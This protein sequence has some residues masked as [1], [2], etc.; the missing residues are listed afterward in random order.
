MKIRKNQRGFALLLFA[1]VLMTAAAAVTIKALNNAGANSQIERDKITAAA[2]AQAKEALIGYAASDATRPGELPCP[3][4][5]G[6]GM[7][8]MGVDYNYGNR[9]CKS[10]IGYLPWKTLDLPELRD[11]AGKHLWYVISPNFYAGNYAALNSDSKGVLPV[12]SEN[13]TLIT[14]QSV[15]IIFSPG[16]ILPN[17]N[18]GNP[19]D[20][21]NYLEQISLNC[22]GSNCINGN[23]TIS[24][25]P[26]IAG[27]ILDTNKITL[28]NDKL[29]LIQTKDLIPVVEKRVAKELF[30]WLQSYYSAN[31]YYPYPA[32]Y[33]HCDNENCQGD[34]SICRGRIPM[35]EASGNANWNPPGWFTTNQWYREI[36]YSVGKAALQSSV[37]IS[38][39]N[40]LTVSGSAVQALFFTPGTPIGAINRPSNTLS[41]Y[42]EDTEN[43]DGWS[44]GANDTYV[45]PTSTALDRDRLYSFP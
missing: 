27:P 31:H 15:A 40:T 8:T 12:Y 28:L 5:D 18:Q 35:S 26:F 34:N 25:G 4:I 13:G 43:Q 37:G 17:I 29:I 10:Y 42:L 2:L 9:S 19:N 11:G 16:E 30:G 39:A 36:Y 3:D 45:I 44:A 33:N 24:T 1:T 32:R 21:S 22:P 20:A 23:N 14:N 38:C 41:D 7:L 6:N